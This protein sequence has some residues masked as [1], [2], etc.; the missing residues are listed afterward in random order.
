MNTAKALKT[1]GPQLVEDSARRRR[2]LEVNDLE[3]MRLPERYWEASFDQVLPKGSDHYLV[4]QKYLDQ[5]H[6]MVDSGYG[7]YL[8][9]HYDMGKTALAAVI[10][11]EAQRCGYSTLFMRSSQISKSAVERSPFDDSSSLFQR[12]LRVDVLAVDD[13]GKEYRS[14]HTGHSASVFDDLIRARVA[15]CRTTLITSNKDPKALSDICKR[16]TLKVFKGSIVDVQVKGHD[17]RAA[18]DKELRAALL[19][20]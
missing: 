4:V 10:L 20:H 13:L 1:M 2:K 14:D 7:L 12:A 17:Y 18:E 3:R 9:G 16:S 5:I 6:R 8:W 19:V 11:K 15:E